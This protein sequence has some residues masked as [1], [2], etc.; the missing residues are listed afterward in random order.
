MNEERAQTI[1]TVA[2]RVLSTRFILIVGL[3]LDFLLFA[4]A[5]F[6]PSYA[7]LGAAAGFAVLVLLAHWLST[8]R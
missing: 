2:L 3:L 1:L 7:R 8:I 6:D 4:Y 5:A